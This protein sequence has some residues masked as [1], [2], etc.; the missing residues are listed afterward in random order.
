MKGKKSLGCSADIVEAGGRERQV[1]RARGRT[2]EWGKVGGRCRSRVQGCPSVGARWPKCGCEI[3]AREGDETP[4]QPATRRTEG[5]GQGSHNLYCSMA[6]CFEA[7]QPK[8]PLLR[9]GALPQRGPCSEAS[10]PRREKAPRVRGPTAP[11]ALPKSLRANSMSKGLTGESSCPQPI[12]LLLTQ[13]SSFTLNAPTHYHTPV[14][15]IY[16]FPHTRVLFHSLV[17]YTIIACTYK[18]PAPIHI[19]N[20]HTLVLGGLRL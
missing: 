12:C 14:H 4:G 19:P 3:G 9:G 10:P 11:P 17:L 16:I 15:T 5:K 13:S 1:G 6:I 2:A 20:P 8:A 7:P 18:L